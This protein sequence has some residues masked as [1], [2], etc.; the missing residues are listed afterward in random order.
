MDEPTVNMVLALT[1]AVAQQLDRPRLS[2]D[3]VEIEERLRL[4]QLDLAA[5]GVRLMQMVITVSR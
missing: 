5:Q 3:L 4:Q 1:Q 2:A